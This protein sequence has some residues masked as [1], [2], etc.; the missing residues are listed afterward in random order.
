MGPLTEEHVPPEAAFNDAKVLFHRM[1]P[2]GGEM[3]RYAGDR[4]RGNTLVVLCK[5]CNNTTGSVCGTEYVR[6]VA[7]SG[8]LGPETEDLAD[9]LA[10]T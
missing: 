10:R 2:I 4:P 8:R 6:F 5:H 9:A 7:C 1:R 3:V